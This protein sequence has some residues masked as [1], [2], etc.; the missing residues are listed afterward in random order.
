MVHINQTV[1]SQITHGIEYTVRLQWK[2]GSLTYKSEK[3]CKINLN[4]ILFDVMSP[5]KGLDKRNSYSKDT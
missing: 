4:Q 3:F 2:S 5:K 1:T